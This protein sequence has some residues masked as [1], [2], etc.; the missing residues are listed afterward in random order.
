VILTVIRH[1][2]RALFD[3]QGISGMTLLIHAGYLCHTA[4]SRSPISRGYPAATGL[5]QDLSSLSRRG[6]AAVMLAWRGRRS[7]RRLLATAAL[8]VH[9]CRP[10]LR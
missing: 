6:T 3:A 2:G 8:I 10:T 4:G 9:D 5:A 1:C 7:L